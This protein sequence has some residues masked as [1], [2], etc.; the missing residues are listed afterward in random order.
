MSSHTAIAPKEQSTDVTAKRLEDVKLTFPTQEEDPQEILVY[1]GKPIFV[2]GPN[3]SGKSSLLQKLHADNRDHARRITAHRQIWFPTN[4][5]DLS[6]AKKLSVDQEIARLDMG[7]QSRWRDDYS[8]QRVSKVLFELIDFED[9]RARKIAAAFD[10]G[11]ISEMEKLKKE[12]SPF[13][14][15]NSLLKM[16]NLSISISIGDNRQ[17]L[18]SKNKSQPYS[19]EELSDGERSALLLAAEV[20]TAPPETLILI[21]EPER[22]LHR[23]IASPLLVALFAEQ[24][25]CA[26]VIS[27]HDVS[28][29]MGIPNATTLLLRSCTWG[30]QSAIEW[31][32]NKVDTDMGISHDIK[33]AIL[34]ARR[35]ILFVEGNANSTDCNTYSILYPEVSVIPCGNCIEVDRAVTGIRN[36]GDLHWVKAYGLIDRDNRQP[37][38]VQNFAE[39]GIYALDCYS[40]ESL[41]YSQTI[42]KKIEEKLLSVSPEMADLEKAK[43][44]IV[45]EVLR[46]REQLCAL[47]IEKRA[48]NA[49]QAQLPT[50]KSLRKNPVHCIKFDASNLLNEEEEKFDKLISSEDTDGLIDRYRVSTTGALNAVAKSFG[51]DGREKYESAVRKLL[52]DDDAARDALRQRLSDLT[53]AIES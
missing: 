35:K 39:R 17:L 14:R 6:P 29:P 49:I 11:D 9:T 4:A 52:V 32:L 42:M 44:S 48:R 1:V 38:E 25:E 50:H 21:D 31:D 16:G 23:S 36:S 27:T 37:E 53:Q 19:I 40:V 12:P 51:F 13:S 46:H 7:K 28:L 30:N 3:G 43:Q 10:S 33:R 5:M 2:I 41:Y 8:N 22:H 20:L 26:F 24:N 18:A 45:E 47:L 34:G 15:L